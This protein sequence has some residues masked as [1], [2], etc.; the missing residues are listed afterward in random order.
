MHFMNTKVVFELPLIGFTDFYEISLE[1][2]KIWLILPNSVNVMYIAYYDGFR[3]NK[4]IFWKFL[5]CPS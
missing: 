5:A 1:M 3:L 2:G 4:N